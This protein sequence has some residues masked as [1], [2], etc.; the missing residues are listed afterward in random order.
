MSLGNCEKELTHF[1]VDPGDALVLFVRGEGDDA[2][3]VL[4]AAAKS[5]D[6][7]LG[8]ARALEFTNFGKFSSLTADGSQ[9]SAAF[10]NCFPLF[11]GS[12]SWG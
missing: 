1:V 4:E 10:A 6:D 2:T 11:Q 8:G 9:S 7:I 5:I 12:H 3:P